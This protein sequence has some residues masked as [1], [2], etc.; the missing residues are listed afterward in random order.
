MGTV[1]TTPTASSGTINTLAQTA[2]VAKTVVAEAQEPVKDG[3]S[4]QFPSAPTTYYWCHKN[5]KVVIQDGVYTTSNPKEIEEL[6]ELVAS[7][8]VWP[9]TGDLPSKFAIPVKPINPSEVN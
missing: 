6:D 5:T 3:T 8:A 7:G 4:Y 2:T 9:Y 1:P